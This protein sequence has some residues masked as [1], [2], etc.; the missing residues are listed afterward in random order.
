MS[1]WGRGSFEND[2]ALD[3]VSD[4]QEYDD[5][6]LV[7]STLEQAIDDDLIRYGDGFVDTYN[8]DTTIAAAEVVAALRGRPSEALPPA[9]TEWIQR[10]SLHVDTN[11]TELAIRIVTRAL[12]TYELG[13]LWA[14]QT[15]YEEWKRVIEDLRLRLQ[16]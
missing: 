10:H 8:V 4:L 12:N 1:A 11:I 14:E 16:T 15:Y 6:D 13:D 2:S 3:W 5:L 7:V 9:L